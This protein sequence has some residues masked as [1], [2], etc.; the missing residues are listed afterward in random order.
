MSA[1]VL[2]VDDDD[3]LRADVAL[4]LRAQGYEVREARSVEDAV[5]LLSVRRPHV[6]LTDLR[7]EGRD[8][9]DLL[10]EM[11]ARSPSTL[12]VLMS[13]FATA[14]DYQRAIDLGA[15]RVLTK[16]FTPRDVCEAVQHAIDCGT[17]FRGSVHGLSLVDMLQM[18]HFAKRSIVLHVDGDG[19][20]R[21]ELVDGE[22]IHA[23]LRALR[24]TD[25][26][27][28]ILATPTGALT[29]SVP[30]TNRVRTIEEPFSQLLMDA[31][32]QLDE[33]EH[34]AASGSDAELDA[35]FATWSSLPPG[36]ESPPAEPGVEAMRSTLSNLLE[37]MAPQLG[38][39]ILL[40]ADGRCVTV[41][42]FAEGAASWAEPVAA[43][44]R[45]AESL[46]EGVE[47]FECVG[48]QVAFSVVIDPGSRACVLLDADLP[49]RVAPQRFRSQTR[50]VASLLW[51]R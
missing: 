19:D 8:G 1:S 31:L 10:V 44:L 39:A 17:G 43:A 32:R 11:R 37:R 48:S 27:R 29:T 35:A 42:N 14:R 45:V 26:L 3:V 46:A 28:A 49:D 40:P 20:G 6:L 50:S 25:A 36:A 9:I 47:H 41:R 13:G 16:P 21:I 18:F 34:A 5:G 2:V 7:M 30:G 22:V 38:A 23:E 4:A 15:V 24:G 51:A 33:S 12:A